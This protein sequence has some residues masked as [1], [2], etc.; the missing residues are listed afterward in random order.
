MVRSCIVALL[1]LAGLAG[2]ARAQVDSTRA[3][4]PGAKLALLPIIFSSPDTRLALGVLPQYI[5]HTAPGTRPSNLR[6]D[7]YYTFNRQFNVLVKPVVWLPGDRWQFAGS[8]RFR[9]WP[10]SF[11]GIGPGSREA[12]EETFTE[13]L[14]HGSVEA[15]RRVRPAVYA[16]AS[17]VMRWGSIREVEPVGGLLDRGAVP[18]TGDSRVAGLGIVATYDTREHVYLPRSGA[19]Y[20]VQVERFARAFGGDRG[21]G[22]VT[23]DLRQYVAVTGP[24]TAAFQVALAM[25][26]GE[27]PFRVMPNVGDIVRGYATTR[28]IDRQRWA[29]QVE[30]RAIPVWWRLGLAVFG[31]AGGVAGRVGDFRT[32]DLN[33]AVGIGLRVLMYPR[34]RITIRQDFAFGQGSSGDYLDLNEAF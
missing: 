32:D 26:D 1:A 4:R 27:V 7:V 6:A 10:T 8:F 9:K 12:D 25:S 5:F 17:Y 23:V 14:A 29:A 15:L 24:V 19:L 11:Y 21:Y 20:R 33:W 22:T 3:E 2:S 16:G 18:G 13:Y 30:I 31:G 28:Y 34:E